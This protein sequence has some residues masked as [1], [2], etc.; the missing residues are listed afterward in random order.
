MR[1]RGILV[2]A[3]G[4]LLWSSP[5]PHAQAA[6]ARHVSAGGLDCAGRAPCH[7]SIQEAVDAADAG[8]IV[9]IQ[10]G[11][12]AEQLHIRDKNSRPG[13][14]EADRIVIQA[15]PAAPAG[16]VVL[17]PSSR[18][19]G[20]SHAV[21][22]QRS[23]F[24]TLRGLTITEA[25]GPA[26]V[27]HGGGH[28][29][30]AVHIERNRIHGNGGSQC[31]GGITV[32]RGNV[33]TVIAHNL[34]HDNG[35][36]GISFRDGHGGPHHVVNN[37]I[38]ANLWN[39]VAVAGRHEVVLV[40]NA[41]TGNGTAP[42]VTGGRHG[43]RW[44]PVM[45][46]SAGRVRLLGNLICGN[47]LGELHGPG[48]DVSDIGN[49]TP[50]GAEGP[51]VI[52][53]PGCHDAAAVYQ[54][55][56]GVDALPGTGDDDFGLTPDAP[57][58]DR[59][60]DPRTLG[61]GVELDP[62]FVADYLEPGVRPRIG[63]AGGLARF[64]IGALE[65]DLP[66]TEP[67]ALTFAAPTA[68]VVGGTLSIEV[69]ARDA[70]GVAALDL[71]ADASPLIVTLLPML[72]A[73]EVTATATWDTT[74]LADGPH[75]LTATARDAAGN[76]TTQTRGVVVDNTPPNTR[77]TDGPGGVLGGAVATF[78][79]AGTDNLTDSGHL[80]F[81]WRIDDGAWAPFA[82]TTTLDV[83]GLGA[84]PHVFEARARDLAGNEDPTP[85][86]WSFTV[87]RVDVLITEPEAG[88]TVAAGTLLVRGV[89]GADGDEVG[90]TVNGFPA[91]VQGSTFVALIPVDAGTTMLTAT[92]TTADTIAVS[93]IVNLTVTG[94][95][96]PSTALRVTP[97]AGVAPLTVAFSLPPIPIGAVM[98][99]DLDG[100]GTVDFLGDHLDG[101][102]FVYPLP[103]LFLPTVTVTDA[104]GT[105]EV[106]QAIVQVFEAGALDALL[107]AKWSAMRDTLR[108]GDITGALTHVAFA[109]RPAYDEA[110]HLI[111]AYLPQVDSL[112][113]DISL[114]DVFDGEAYYEATR[115]DD[116]ID[117]SFA[118][119]FLLDDDGLWR[120]D[121]F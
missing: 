112:L 29:N 74:A 38:H 50:T 109:S 59:G 72:P 97:A 82:A 48:L 77:I 41:V 53:S 100:D 13:A 75:T 33:D 85:A 56:A 67:P 18:H 73:V 42:G 22:V 62:V 15:D 1:I 91:A 55:L 103:G 3:L 2:A 83:G 39:G 20:D 95:A 34:I 71:R 30:V 40:N 64:D 80:V 93:H 27:L 37:T 43:V 17:A 111:A 99:L 26:V 35:R 46:P 114:V 9:V 28:G 86:R 118:I 54:D 52:A 102:T 16:S 70:G 121:A 31:D 58:L 12:Y 11:R 36:D 81:T 60:I 4:L 84:G 63:I 57:A 45:P 89:V 96:G 68:G 113:T 119:R 47:R 79:L 106:R 98:R 32:A 116:G 76:P 78:T 61:L 105:H 14:T 6:Q 87:V 7:A 107:R 94:S 108:S 23:R 24:V 120:V 90:V 51:G 101:E 104:Q 65:A 10:A 110:F 44:E 21:R 5:A 25:G 49:V 115:T 88:T 19:C 8:D 69:R 117:R 66:D 92:A